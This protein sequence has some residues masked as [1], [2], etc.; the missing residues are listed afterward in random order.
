[1]QGRGIFDINRRQAPTINKNNILFCEENLS[2][3][4]ENR[5]VV[6]IIDP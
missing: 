5:F 1:M 2:F 4:G 6:I 3:S